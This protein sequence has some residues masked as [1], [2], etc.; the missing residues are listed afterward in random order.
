ML[1]DAMPQNVPKKHPNRHILRADTP[2]DKPC[3]S[4]PASSEGRADPDW[5]R[6]A[7]AFSFSC[8]VRH[9]SLTDSKK[10]L[11]FPCRLPWSPAAAARSRL[12]SLRDQSPSLSRSQSASSPPTRCAARP[13]PGPSVRAAVP[14][15][16]AFGEY[17]FS[18]D[19]SGILFELS[20]LAQFTTLYDLAC[21]PA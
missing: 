19:I 15:L 11:R 16:A 7:V 21:L 18:A 13:S 4:A 5:L 2:L 14:P 10:N 1:G 3:V 8:L 20:L 6:S 17:C 9:L 12:S